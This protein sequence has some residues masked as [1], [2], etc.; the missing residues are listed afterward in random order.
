M[1]F[2]EA[3]RYIVWQFHHSNRIERCKIFFLIE[4][5]TTTTLYE[6]HISLIIRE[7]NLSQ[8]GIEV[9]LYNC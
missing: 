7:Y 2:W 4:Y 5:S 1:I 9:S 8:Q 3:T 6:Q